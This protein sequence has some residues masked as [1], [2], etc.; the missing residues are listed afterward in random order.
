MLEYLPRT[1]RAGAQLQIAGYEES[2]ML[3]QRLYE[4]EIQPHMRSKVCKPWGCR[5]G[6]RHDGR[7]FA[8]FFAAHAYSFLK[9]YE[10]AQR[11]LA[12]KLAAE[13][14]REQRRLP[15]ELTENA[16]EM[17]IE[18]DGPSRRADTLQEE[19]LGG[20]LVL[21]EDDLHKDQCAQML[22]TTAARAD[23]G[24]LLGGV[25][26][27]KVLSQFSGIWQQVSWVPPRSIVHLSLSDYFRNQ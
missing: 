12:E 27:G 20:V 15:K 16:Q 3:E 7:T 8:K 22:R 24:C 21:F 17:P 25:S 5:T 23:R 13:T 18:H 4:D 6:K 26:S 14:S 2:L 1:V 11:R 19:R 9:L 10:R